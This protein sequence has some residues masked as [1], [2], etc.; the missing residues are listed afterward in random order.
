MIECSNNAF[1]LT[2]KNYSYAFYV[3]DIGFLQNLHYGAKICN[4]DMDFLIS[5]GK[6]LSP[7]PSDLNGD[8]QL[9]IMP[10]EYGFF[11]RGDFRDPSAIFVRDDGAA[12]SRLRY[13]SHKI[14]DG[15][16]VFNGMPHIRRG[17]KTLE[18]TL[19]DDF[20][21]IEVVLYYT[22]AADSDVLV[23]N[24]VIK[25]SGDTT[26]SIKKAFSFRMDLPHDKYS[27]M[28]FSG[29][30]AGERYPELEKI[31]HG[32][33]RLQSLRG[34][35]SHQTNPFTVILRQDCGEDAGECYGIHLMYSGSFA[36]T[37]EKSRSALLTVQG[38]I[39]DT[40]FEWKLHG[41][42]EFVTPQ[43]LL[44]YSGT[45]VGGMSRSVSRF[46]SDYVVN[47][48][49]AYADRPIV[50]NN[51]EATYF[52]FDNEKLYPIIDA[53]ADLG[54][55]T[56]VLDDG[57]F[58]SRDDDKRGLGDWFVNDKKLKGGLRAIIDR[59]K[60]HGLKF[61]LWFEPEMVN[62]DSEL[63]RAHP[64]WAIKKSDVTPCRSRNQLVLD[65]T[66]KEVVDYIY[67]LVAKI[68]KENDISYV[69]WDMNRP[70]TEFYS[71][72]LPAEQMGEFAHRYVLGV[73]DLAER[74]TSE[75]P[76][77]FFEGCAGG[78]GR[79]DVGMLY[80]F[81]QIWTSDCTDAYERA[82]I[83]W[84]TSIGYPLSAMS[85]HVSACPN[86]QTWR[87]ASFFT[88][89][90]IASLGAFGYELDLS[91]L[92]DK[93]KTTVRSIT[94]SYKRIRQLIVNGDLYRLCNPF[95]NDYFC[96]QVVSRDKS[97]SYIVGMHS[98]RVSINYDR[99]VY[100]RGLS[101]DKKYTVEELGITA[102]GT[103]L[104]QSGLILPKLNDF[105]GWVWHI[106]E[107]E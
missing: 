39:N 100:L 89:G 101:P 60:K 59:C 48:Q 72:T 94:E 7:S 64:D 3:N 75:F 83:Q 78:G 1:L 46:I 28:R 23:R 15:A 37:A 80:Y 26:I 36:I 25:N 104:M 71:S 73:Y 16:P 8:M 97:E 96:E 102:S 106:R 33:T 58:G 99:P 74:L 62:E 77:V 51:W 45:G 103:A 56:F 22:V 4:A 66:R 81:P 47:P 43:V 50:V 27:M 34:M 92:S 107:T 67:S 11:A 69:K 32:I 49:R 24:V 2:G 52:D 21:D 88:R 53:A 40:G 42:E 95:N 6:S 85:C 76:E 19:K 63:F 29:T 9:D 61:G 70:L 105:E 86:H 38:G 31:G 17:D 13:S 90:A 5:K 14:V 65:F 54:I 44:T 82:K 30:W 98:V 79:F 12:M 87:T 57:W 20:S 68:L 41:G 91:K 18:V 55:D 10:S 35:S 93:E 84:G